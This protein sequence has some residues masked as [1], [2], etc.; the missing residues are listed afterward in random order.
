MNLASTNRAGLALPKPT[1]R[2]LQAPQM[3]TPILSFHPLPSTL[4]SNIILYLPFLT[5]V[6]TS[7]QLVNPLLTPANPSHQTHSHL[8]FLEQAHTPKS[9]A[10][11]PTGAELG[12]RELDLHFAFFGGAA[13]DFDDGAAGEGGELGGGEAG[14]DG[15]AE[16]GLEEGGGLEK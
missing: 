2:A 9:A 1:L 3:T 5:T 8:P 12:A 15:G 16:E 6:A 10:I 11:D 7:P 14:R 4:F 13:G